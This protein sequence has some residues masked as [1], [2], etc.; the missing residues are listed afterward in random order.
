MEH[1]STTIHRSIRTLT[2]LGSTKRVNYEHFCF[3]CREKQSHTWFAKFVNVRPARNHCNYCLLIA[4][5][6]AH[7]LPYRTRKE[8]T[9]PSPIFWTSTTHN[10]P[11]KIELRSGG[12]MYRKIWIYYHRHKHSTH[13]SR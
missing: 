5:H 9:A 10:A 4:I 6:T 13:W 8:Y 3:C 7:V 2:A 11:T 12:T 1:I